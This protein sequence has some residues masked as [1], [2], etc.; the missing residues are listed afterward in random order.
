MLLIGE[1]SGSIVEQGSASNTIAQKVEQIAQMAEANSRASSDSA[2][3][4]QE[5]RSQASNIQRTVAQYQV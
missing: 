5:L 2:G 3:S 4:A 1:I